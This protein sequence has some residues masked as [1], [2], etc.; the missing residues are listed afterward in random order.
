[1][2]FIEDSGN[3]DVQYGER[4]L[5]FMEERLGL[6]CCRG[7]SWGQWVEVAGYPELPSGHY[8]MSRSGRERIRPQE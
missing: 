7:E 4:R 5:M 3:G 1:M 8:W 2:S 6:G